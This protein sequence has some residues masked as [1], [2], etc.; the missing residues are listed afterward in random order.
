MARFIDPKDVLDDLE[1]QVALTNT[2]NRLR[3]NFDD[4]V[5]EHIAVAVE[6][7]ARAEVLG[8]IERGLPPDVRDTV[9]QLA[10]D[11]EREL[12]QI[13]LPEGETCTT[14]DPIP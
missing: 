12:S 6:E 10:H 11:I 2:A 4:A 5:R 9:K 13:W 7:A 1:Q 8:K 3:A 14:H